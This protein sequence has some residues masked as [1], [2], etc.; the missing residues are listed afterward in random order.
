MRTRE[1]AEIES[2]DQEKGYRFWT[3]GSF[4]SM[5]LGGAAYLVQFEDQ[6][7]RYEVRSFKRAVLPFHMEVLALLMAVKQAEYMSISKCR[8]YTDSKLLV[9]TFDPVRKF[10]PLQSADWR[11]YA[12]LSQIGMIL[13]ANPLYY[14]VLKTREENEMAHLLANWARKKQADYV[15]FTFPLFSE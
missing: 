11:S 1:I 15:G 7:I 4:D 12:E 8:F 2:S 5:E 3:D 14:C 13:K 6:L 10:L 9:E